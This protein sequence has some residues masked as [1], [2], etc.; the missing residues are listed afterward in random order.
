MTYTPKTTPYPFQDVGSRFLALNPGAGLFDECGLGKSKQVLDAFGMLQAIG[1]ARR[2]LVVCPASLVRNWCDE[3]EK[4]SNFSYVALTQTTGNYRKVDGWAKSQGNANMFAYAAM[5][6]SAD[7]TI[8]NYAK[9]RL[10]K[11]RRLLPQFDI[12]VCDEAHRIKNYSAQQTRAIMNLEPRPRYRWALTGTPLAERPEDVWTI[13]QW[14]TGWR[15][16]PRK[17]QAFK[18]R[19]IRSIPVTT[20]DGRSFPKFLGYQNLEEL[21][22]KVAQFSLR[23]TK[24]DVLPDLPPKLFTTRRYPMV[25]TQEKAYEAMRKEMVA[26]LR[27]LTEEEWQLEAGNAMVQAGRLRQMASNLAHVGGTDAGGKYDGL[28]ELLEDVAPAPQKCVIWSAWRSGVE[29]AWHQIANSFGNS[30]TLYAHGGLSQTIR[31]VNVQTWKLVDDCRFLVA[32]PHSLGEGHN[33]NA[34]SVEVV[35]D[36][37]WSYLLYTQALD[38]LHR[39]GQQNPVTVVNVLATYRDGRDTIDAAVIGKLQAKAEAAATVLGEEPLFGSRKEIL[40]AIS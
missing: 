38:R 26:W 15:I 6:M 22:G 13:G 2:M 21:G 19:Y 9:I 35:L 1:E 28:A 25:A 23:R 36:A 37:P 20:R 3:I 31:Q 17:L 40:E 5:E 29:L 24:S 12:L 8:I 33:L 10:S 7:I 11:V 32:T 18:A 27:G 30:S 34:A 16:F 39:I 4:H 14:L